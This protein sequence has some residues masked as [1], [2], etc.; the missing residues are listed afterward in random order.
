LRDLGLED[1]GGGGLDWRLKA[2]GLEVVKEEGAVGAGA[3]RYRER[4]RYATG[5]K[6]SERRT[7]EYNLNRLQEIV[8]KLENPDLPLEESLALYEEGMVVTEVC[9]GQ[10]E[11]AEQK[12]E[13]LRAKSS[14][15]GKGRLENVAA[16]RRTV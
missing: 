8:A 12:V 15:A 7:F 2:R 3:V 1:A 10:L 9:D 6:M 4:S 5:L 16:A 14:A 13:A 11:A